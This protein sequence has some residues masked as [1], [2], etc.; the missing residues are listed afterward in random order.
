M[1]M[2]E[3]ESLRLAVGL[4]YE[5]QGIKILCCTHVQLLRCLL[6]PVYRWTLDSGM[7]VE[8]LL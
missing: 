6:Y 7:H 5:L 3:V 1:L 8:S 2:R 4:A